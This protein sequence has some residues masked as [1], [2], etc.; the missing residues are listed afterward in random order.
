MLSSMHTYRLWEEK[1]REMKNQ[2][3]KFQWKEPLPYENN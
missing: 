1:L 3:T 2:E